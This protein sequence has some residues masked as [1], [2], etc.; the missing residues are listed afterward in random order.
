[1]NISLTWLVLLCFDP[2]FPCSLPGAAILK[3]KGRHL[4]L[5]SDLGRPLLLMSDF[6]SSTFAIKSSAGSDIDKLIISSPPLI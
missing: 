3:M 4:G 6:R 1:M 5:I 2:P